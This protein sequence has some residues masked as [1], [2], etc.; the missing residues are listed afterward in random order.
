[1]MSL[2]KALQQIIILTVAILI[3]SFSDLDAESPTLAKTFSIKELSIFNSAWV[4]R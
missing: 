2:G 3:L 4:T 1:M